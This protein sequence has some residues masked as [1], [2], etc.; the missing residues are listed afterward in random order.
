MACGK[1]NRLLRRAQPVLENRMPTDNE[2]CELQCAGCPGKTTVFMKLGPFVRGGPQLLC[3][4]HCWSLLYRDVQEMKAR[5][6][7]PVSVAV[8]QQK[9]VPVKREEGKL[10]EKVL[11]EQ[12][13]KDRVNWLFSD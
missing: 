2:T 1:D 11:S 9:R 10:F 13:Q 12:A 5:R 6:G 4:S 8:R 3:C 7:P